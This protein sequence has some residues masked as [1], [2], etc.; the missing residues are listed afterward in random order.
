[1][2]RRAQEL[3]RE[4]PGREPKEAQSRVRT[5]LLKIDVDWQ[6]LSQVVEGL[7][8]CGA[9]G[10]CNEAKAHILGHAQGGDESLFVW[11]SPPKLGSV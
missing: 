6:D 9:E 3:Q 4:G 10:P 8:R 2:P 11:R 1:M 7:D 5:E